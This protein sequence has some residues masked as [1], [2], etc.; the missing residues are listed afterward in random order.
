[1]EATTISSANDAYIHVYIHMHLSFQVSALFWFRLWHMYL[2]D[3]CVNLKLPATATTTEMPGKYSINYI[4]IFHIHIY[5]DLYADPV[6]VN[7]IF[8]TIWWRG[9]LPPTSLH[10]LHYSDIAMSAMASQITGILIV[11]STVCTGADKKKSVKAPHHWPLRG[12]STGD[13]WIPLTKGQ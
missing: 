7:K 9:L 5:A 13:R 12:E 4:Y 2:T 3:Q 10:L 6:Y 8:F 11:C 1:M